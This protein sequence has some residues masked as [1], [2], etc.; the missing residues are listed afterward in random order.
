MEDRSAGRG[1]PISFPRIVNFLDS[2]GRV[3]PDGSISI[4]ISSSGSMDVLSAEDRIC[5][6][7]VSRGRGRAPYVISLDIC[8]QTKRRPLASSE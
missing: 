3:D 5:R 2:R 7:S 1:I 8:R 6:L 4:C